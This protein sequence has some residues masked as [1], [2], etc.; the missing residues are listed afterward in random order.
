MSARPRAREF[1]D[2]AN[3]YGCEAVPQIWIR[4]T[5]VR[6]M[7]YG[8]C[9]LSVFGPLIGTVL[10][11]HGSR[12]NRGHAVE[13]V[14]NVVVHV[15]DYRKLTLQATARLGREANGKVLLEFEDGSSAWFESRAREFH[16]AGKSVLAPGLTFVGDSGAA[17]AVGECVGRGGTAEVYATVSSAT[18]TELVTKCL[19]P[20]RF[21]I[22][23]LATR[24]ER[25]ATH[26]AEVSHPNVISFV[27]RANHGAQLVVV[28]ERGRET[29]AERTHRAPPTL[30]LARVWLLQLLGGVAHLHSRGLVHRDLTPKNFIFGTNDVLKVAD[31]GTLRSDQDLDATSEVSNVRL[32]SL[33]YISSEQ[34]TDPHAATPAD[35]VF[36][37]GQV[38]YFLLS[39]VVPLGNP[40]P[41]AA[42]DVPSDL[43]QAVER[44]RAYRRADRFESAVEALSALEEL[45]GT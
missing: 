28:M 40:P 35:D 6:G 37:V 7:S 34:R 14:A 3:D 29:L 18:S 43:V 21:L 11:A 10:A 32:G 20:R 44:M 42:F 27:D 41:L 23:D 26:L 16:R 39:G 15:K 31:F 8:P 1:L 24:F 5:R 25:E 45:T 38:A 9:R 33:V 17:Y 22:E 36:S 19:S 13:L 12:A 30:S 2:I 4:P